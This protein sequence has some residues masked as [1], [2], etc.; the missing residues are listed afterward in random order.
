[1]SGTVVRN[2]HRAEAATIAT[3]G[4]D[5]YGMRKALAELGLTYLDGPLD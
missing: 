2:I 1:M 4:L 3:L 5:L